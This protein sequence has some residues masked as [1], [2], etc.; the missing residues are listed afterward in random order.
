MRIEKMRRT[1][2]RV[3]SRRLKNFNIDQVPELESDLPPEANDKSSAPPSGNSNGG[4]PLFIRKTA[5]FSAAYQSGKGLQFYRNY[6][7]INPHMPD[8]RIRS[9]AIVVKPGHDEARSTAAE[10]TDWL[11]ARGIERAGDTGLCRHRSTATRSLTSMPTFLW[12]LAAT[13]RCS[14]PLG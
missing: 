3:F 14:R 9:V 1:K 2:L 11:A 6:L 13:A 12:C 10:L 8:A 5:A 4:E 7:M